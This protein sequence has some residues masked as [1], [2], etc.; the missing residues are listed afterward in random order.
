[1]R[2]NR[3][4]V[5]SKIIGILAVFDLVM[6]CFAVPAKA[7]MTYYISPAGSD[8]AS[9]SSTQP[10]RTFS[11]AWNTLAPGDTLIVKSGTYSGSTNNFTN[12]PSG[13][14][15]NYINIRAE[16]EGAV[17]IT[18]SFYISA[19][20]LTLSGFRFRNQ[21]GE[22]AIDGNHVKVFRSAFE[23]GAASGNV[24]NFDI[25]GSYDLM[26]D[27]WFYGS[28]GRY[29]IMIYRAD[30]IVLRRLVFRD[31]AGWSDTKGDPEA[32]LVIYESSNVAVQNNIG[33]DFDLNYSSSY[34]GPYYLTGHNGNPNSSNAEYLGNMAINYKGGGFYA[35]TDDG[36]TN[37]VVRD[38]VL[39]SG[40]DGGFFS[41][42][43]ITVQRLTVGG[44]GSEQGIGDW[45]DTA[46]IH[47]TDSLVFDTGQSARYATVTYTNTYNP[48][49]LSGTG[50]THVNPRT[51]GLL[52]LP[53]I[54]SGSVLKTG[55]VSNGQRGAQITT[56]IGVSG[57]LWGE[58]GYNT[59][60]GEALWP[61]PNEAR[62]K[63]EMCTDA[64]VTRGFCGSTS[65][66]KY[67]WEYLGNGC[68]ADICSGGST[69]PPTPKTGDL[70]SDNAVDILDYNL[71]VSHFGQTG[72]GV[73]GDINSSGKVDIFDFNLLVGNFG[74]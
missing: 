62:I 33:I 58:A 68:P 47:V 29:K 35:D 49:D 51:N 48:S 19:S 22:K 57:T 53:R 40:R 2:L 25:G 18:S 37:V 65:L 52:Y 41:S 32:G 16:T 4:R 23:G 14:A 10:W 12:L 11:K 31:D 55:G 39:Y 6:F 26:E 42:I 56:K 9:G 38:M 5:T 63:Q 36:A 28:G 3:V 74:T 20:Y 66:T 70:N 27:C 72:S 24:V 44:T 45:T 73:V 30:H 15:G 64:G 46:A 17:I 54:E 43:P 67:I 59:D 21:E 8:I 61:W 69:P 60:T 34:V 13:T 7:A 50:I 71:L 1:M